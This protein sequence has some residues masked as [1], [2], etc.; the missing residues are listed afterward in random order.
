MRKSKLINIL[1]L[2]I[3]LSLLLAACSQG[4]DKETNTSSD[5][6]SASES[7][8]QNTNASGDSGQV[9]ELDVIVFAHQLTQDI[10]SFSQF[11]ELEEKTGVKINWE[12]VRSDFEEKI[13]LM[14]S[15]DV[16]D[17]PDVI[18]G[19]L[20]MSQIAQFKP[21]LTAMDE[22]IDTNNT[23]N[24]SKAFADDT[25][26]L[27]ISTNLDGHIYALGNKKPFRPSS[28]SLWMINKTWLDQLGMEIPKTLDELKTALLAF[29]DNDMNG[30]GDTSDE[31]PMDWNNDNNQNVAFSAINLTAAYGKTPTWINI[32]DEKVSYLPV[33]E[34]YKQTVIFLH[35]LYSENLINTEVFTQGY[36]QMQARAQNEDAPLVG[37]TF[38]W[39][40]ADRTGKWADQYVTMEA[41]VAQGVSQARTPNDSMGL[42]YQQITAVVPQTGNQEAAIKWLDNFYTEDMAVQNYFG[43]F[44]VVTEKDGDNYNTLPLP[45]GQNIDGWQWINSLKDGAP[46]YYSSDLEARTNVWEAALNRLN[47]E[48][49]YDGTRVDLVKDT[50]P[51]AQYNE[52]DN[53]KLILEQDM[54]SIIYPKWSEWIVYGGIEEE[55]DEYVATINQLGLEELLDVWQRAYNNFYGK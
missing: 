20:N 19:G 36:S 1:A 45:D 4:G 48:E 44:G 9:Q 49:V 55:W 12:Y 14:F 43:P 28:T 33:S 53:E 54:N 30:N 31:I 47:I 17:L 26:L 8:N 11:K 10:G 25:T 5:S 46:M 35:D 21:Y 16:E 51:L 50:F 2:V 24:I 22:Y 38:G 23:P 29:R 39:D 34:E 3:A 40:I 52:E 42:Q 7:G 37:F 27:N 18:I 6:G 32:T 15:G 13:S 41:L